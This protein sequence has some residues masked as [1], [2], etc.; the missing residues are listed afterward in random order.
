MDR[1]KKQGMQGAKENKRKGG[2]AWQGLVWAQGHDEF[3]LQMI[4]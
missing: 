1:N 2:K 4:L 3:K